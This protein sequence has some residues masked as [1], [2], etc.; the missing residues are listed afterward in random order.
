MRFLALLD[1]AKDGSNQRG[2]VANLVIDRNESVFESAY[3]QLGTLPRSQAVATRK[4][5]V[6]FAAQGAMEIGEDAGGLSREFFSVLSSELAL[7]DLFV[8]SGVN[9]CAAPILG[10]PAFSPRV[11]PDIPELSLVLDE[12]PKEVV[13]DRMTGS[14]WALRAALTGAEVE[15]LVSGSR[16]IKSRKLEFVG[17][18]LGFA[19]RAGIPMPLPLAPSC[20]A[21][22][23]GLDEELDA[24]R[25]MS[26]LKEQDPALFQ[27]L[28]SILEADEPQELGLVFTASDEGG[29]EVELCADGA[30][31]EVT[32]ANRE[33][34]VCAYVRERLRIGAPESLAMRAGFVTGTGG[35][36]A[37]KALSI[38][39]AQDLGH[40]LCGAE[41]I[42]VEDW[43]T[44]TKFV[45]YDQ[46]S[47]QVGW[48][49][50]SL[51][52][53]SQPERCQ[54]LKFVTGSAVL[55]HG[56][57]GGYKNQQGERLKCTI[58]KDRGGAARLPSASTCFAQLNL[59]EYGSAEELDTKLRLA[60]ELGQEG[61]GLV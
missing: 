6:Q 24:A 57:W 56:G 9:L 61:F 11:L 14:A 37:A 4:L 51:A 34:F 60:V 31:V 47:E 13:P 16:S 10:E 28:K 50:Q 53:F 19:L 44:H 40:L 23:L 12:A 46:S 30:D 59:P 33:A 39:S 54:L 22:L 32:A 49:W 15:A 43:R 18:L 3:N 8:V 20:L 35:P 25:L 1:S 38:F 5:R 17:R 2:P 26:A 45:A 58:S 42:S 52:G 7:S 27:G 21:G 48:F 55:P 29:A 36:V 41:E